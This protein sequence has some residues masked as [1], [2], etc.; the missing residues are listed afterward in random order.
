MN[1]FIELIDRLFCWFPRIVMIRPDQ[2]GV[3]VT[4]RRVKVLTAGHY[5]YFPLFQSMCIICITP[6]PIDMRG[7][8]C[9]TK[10]RVDMVVSACIIYKVTDA[11]KAVLEV[12]D[13]DT[14][15]PALALGVVTRFVAQRMAVD[16]TIGD[17]SN[18]DSNSE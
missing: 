7:Q 9:L 5:L 3:R 18:D 2:G 11:K 12:Y 6:Q 10:D 8:S 13:Y 14:S 15:L 4:G 16:C 1:W 17:I